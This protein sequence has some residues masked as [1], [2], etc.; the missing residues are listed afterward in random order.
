MQL[1]LVEQER[2]VMIACRR[3]LWVGS[4]KYMI[5]IHSGLEQVVSKTIFV[6]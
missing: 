2:L 4:Q 3:T 5:A 1:T 6:S